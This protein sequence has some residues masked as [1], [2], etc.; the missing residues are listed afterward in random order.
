MNNEGLKSEN[1]V[2]EE[3]NEKFFLLEKIK[4]L[5]EKIKKLEGE[6][7]NLMVDSVTKLKTRKYFE[8]RMKEII[9]SLE[10]T[11]QD[12]R[13]EGYRNFSIIFCDLDKFKEVNDTLGHQEGDNVLKKVSEIIS[14][15]VRDTDVVSR[16]GGDEIA[17][18]LMGAGEEEAVKK[19]EEIR[20]AVE[21]GLREYGV[22]LSVGVVS[23]EGGLNVE[24]V[25]ERADKA[26]YLAKSIGKNNVKTYTD[27][28][29]A[30][31]KEK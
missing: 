9:S 15:K 20:A 2:G 17:I 24:L 14:G 29:S 12:K 30:S 23:C 22:T 18:G 4:E 10:N 16:W 11:G 31:K 21:D 27:V 1:I 13:K 8:E 26:L 25:M 7:Q 6:N 19:G 5:E 28:L 3:K